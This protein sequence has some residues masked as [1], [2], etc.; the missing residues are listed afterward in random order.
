MMATLRRLF[1][2]LVISHLPLY[3]SEPPATLKSIS[4]I[5][6]HLFTGNVIG[7]QTKLITSDDAMMQLSG[8]KKKSVGL[9][10][11]YSLLIPGMGELYAGTFETGKYFLIGEGILWLTYA[12]FEVYGNSIRDDSRSYAATHAG[13]SPNGKS[14]Q[15]FIDIGN[16]STVSS[17]N[18]AQLRDRTPENLYDPNAGFTWQWDSEASRLSYRDQRIASENMYNDRRFVVGA[19][20][21]NHL[22]SAI[23]A[24]RSAVLH[25]KSLD[26]HSGDLRLRAGVLGG[27]AHPHGIVITLSRS[28]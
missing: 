28:L 9:A 15:F 1:L 12:T 2:L 5:R 10:A 6:N 3:A 27:V 18:E 14:D 11:M 22:A 23:H 8:Q 7:A 4:E 20:L 13:L 25:N 17:Y 21:I 16:Y 19:I 24:A 26:E